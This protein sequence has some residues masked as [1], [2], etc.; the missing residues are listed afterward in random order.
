MTNFLWPLF[1][2]GDLIGFLVY[3]IT[4][5]TVCAVEQYRYYNEVMQTPI[6]NS[7]EVS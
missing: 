4:V 6:Q 2:G 5:A 7:N 1:A 3:F